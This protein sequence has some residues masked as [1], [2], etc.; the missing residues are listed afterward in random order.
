[1]RNADYFDLSDSQRLR[2]IAE[3]M[4]KRSVDDSFEVEED[5]ERIAKRMELLQY[6][7]HIL[8][9][10]IKRE[11]RY[12]ICQRIMDKLIGAFSW[13]KNKNAEN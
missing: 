1:M 10:Q 3:Y 13:K 6:T 2:T 12:T 11:S 8:K 5:L 4:R 7:N 9:E